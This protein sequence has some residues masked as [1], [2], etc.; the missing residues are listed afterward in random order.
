MNIQK[1]V[2]HVC[3]NTLKYYDTVLRIVRSKSRKTDHVKVPRL[4][5]PH[6]GEIHRRLPKIF[7]HINN[8]RP[9]SYAE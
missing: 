8:T 6:C 5:C 3:G 2:C 4:R 1:P 7:S 9:K